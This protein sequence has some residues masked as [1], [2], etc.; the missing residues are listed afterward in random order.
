MNQ[1]EILYLINNILG[2]IWSFV[3]GILFF[4]LR[5][6]DKSCKILSLKVIKSFYYLICKVYLW[7][8]RLNLV[9]VVRIWT[10]R[11]LRSLKWLL[12]CYFPLR[13]ISSHQY[14]IM[15]PDSVKYSQR[16]NKA[17]CL[18]ASCTNNVRPFG[19]FRIYK[20]M[21]AF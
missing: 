1:D 20:Y 6:R 5:T 2:G 11:G 16:Y 15:Q 9:K 18:T 17:L 19:I 3:S 4:T 7:T 14:L 21:G 13:F 12:Q 10:L 8:S